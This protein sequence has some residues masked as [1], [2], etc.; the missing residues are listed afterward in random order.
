[1]SRFHLHNWQWARIRRTVLDADNWKCRNC[2]GYGNEVDHIIPLWK[3]GE[4]Y[5]ADN[6]QTLCR[7]CHID[8][9]RKEKG[10]NPSLVAGQ[11][12]WDVLLQQSIK[13]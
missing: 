11:R 2:G 9:T 5:Q 1:M 3:N 4:P 13:E 7:D 6:L 8:K 12:A 10:A